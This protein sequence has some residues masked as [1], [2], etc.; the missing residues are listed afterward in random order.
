MP[1]TEQT[2]A[3]TKMLLLHAINLFCDSLM[4]CSH[5][6]LDIPSRLLR[7]TVDQVSVRCHLVYFFK[8]EERE[9]Q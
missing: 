8:G 6:C 9:L 3:R 2:V 1:D 4:N 5:S 7:I